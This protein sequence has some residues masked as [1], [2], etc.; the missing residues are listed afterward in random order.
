M[1]LKI[2]Y[3]YDDMK[4]LKRSHTYDAGADCH[5]PFDVTLKPGENVIPLGFKL[6]IPPGYAGF[7]SLRSSWMNSGLI[8]NYVPFDTGF[9]GEWDMRVYNTTDNNISI[10]KGERICQLIIQPILDV[11]FVSDLGNLRTDGKAG[12]TGK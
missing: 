5:L 6:V 8:C 3:L 12:S 9:S 7:L 1:K 4:P 2:E 11:D 10:K